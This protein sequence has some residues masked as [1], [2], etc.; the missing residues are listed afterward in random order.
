M[1]RNSH[2]SLID[3]ATAHLNGEVQVR[4]VFNTLREMTGRVLEIKAAKQSKAF[5]WKAFKI[6]FDKQYSKLGLDE[7]M[8]EAM[9]F[10]F[11]SVEAVRVQ[12]Q[13]QLSTFYKRQKAYNQAKANDPEF[14]ELTA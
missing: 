9:K 1:A 13:K 10:G 4:M 3:T 7:L 2:Q 14:A 6:A 12:R 5:D 8:A 11:T